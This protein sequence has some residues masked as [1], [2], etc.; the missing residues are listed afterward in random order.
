[1][2]KKTLITCSIIRDALNWL[3]VG[4]I[5]GVCQLLDVPLLIMHYKYAGPQASWTL[6]ELIPMV[7]LIPIFTIAACNYP[8]PVGA[9]Q[10]LPDPAVRAAR[11]V[12]SPASEPMLFA[13]VDGKLVPIHLSPDQ[14]AQVA[15]HV[16]GR[17]AGGGHV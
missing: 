7:G 1:M 14:Q 15:R 12:P 3:L 9:T 16:H 11:V 10:V 4:Q 6:L 13:Q 8:D 17:E 5:P 2:T